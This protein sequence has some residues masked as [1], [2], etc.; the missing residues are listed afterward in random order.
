MG[1]TPGNP[2]RLIRRE[3]EPCQRITGGSKNDACRHQGS[4]VVGET[5]LAGVGASTGSTDLCRERAARPIP[6]NKPTVVGQRTV[7]VRNEAV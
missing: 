3:P 6:S 1:Q 4:V 5:E 7:V 2:I